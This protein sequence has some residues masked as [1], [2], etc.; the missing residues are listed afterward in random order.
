MLDIS[1]APLG[2]RLAYHPQPWLDAR[3]AC[4]PRRVAGRRHRRS[5]HRIPHHRAARHAF[6]HPLS[7]DAAR[8]A[9]GRPRPRHGARTL[10]RELSGH[11]MRRPAWRHTPRWGCRK[12]GKK[13]RVY[14]K[15]FPVMALRRTPTKEIRLNAFS[16]L[17]LEEI[18]QACRPAGSL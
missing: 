10:G 9:G 8:G 16:Y 15:I 14:H 7:Q 11:W 13:S 12:R 17:L 3:S 1:A 6:P 2:H 18:R 5:P 4:H